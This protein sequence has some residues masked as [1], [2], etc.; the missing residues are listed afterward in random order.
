MF[1]AFGLSRNAR[2][3][4]STR[5]R[6]DAG[7]RERA[8]AS[9]RTQDRVGRF[10]ANPIVVDGGALADTSMRAP[11]DRDAGRTLDGEPRPACVALP[12]LAWGCGSRRKGRSGKRPRIGPGGAKLSGSQAPVDQELHA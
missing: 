1:V 8:C 7:V 5:G 6:S 2:K 4:R 12:L 3:L 11:P 9:P 10:A